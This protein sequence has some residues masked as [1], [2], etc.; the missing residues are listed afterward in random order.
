MV[1]L[2]FEHTRLQAFAHG[3]KKGFTAPV[4]LFGRFADPVNIPDLPPIEVKTAQV[5]DWEMVGADIQ[6]AINCYEAEQHR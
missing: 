5:S 1:I 6:K 2:N 4:M 3:F